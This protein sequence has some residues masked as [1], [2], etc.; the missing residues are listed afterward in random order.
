[1]DEHQSN[2]IS[3]LQFVTWGW[4]IIPLCW[5]NDQ[6]NCGCGRNHGGA[7]KA[8]LTTKGVND[9]SDQFH[10]VLRWWNRWPEANI[11]IDLAKSGLFV[12]GPDSVEWED[13]FRRQGLPETLTA[14][15]GG[16]EGHYHYYY[17]KPENV[18][19]TRLNRSGEYDLQTQGYMVAAPS[20]HQSGNH[21][22]WL[23]PEM[24]EKRIRGT[25]SLP[26]PPQ[27]AI[28][29]L[30]ERGTENKERRQEPTWDA[31]PTPPVID[32][33]NLDPASHKWW[34]GEAANMAGKN[35]DRSTTLFRLGTILAKRGYD[36]PTIIAALH[37][38]DV[39]LGYNKFARRADGGIRAYSDIATKVMIDERGRVNR[40]RNPAPPPD[41]YDDEGNP[42]DPQAP[43][44]PT[45][46]ADDIGRSRVAEYFQHVTR[47]RHW[48]SDNMRR[49]L[50]I[51]DTYKWLPSHVLFENPH[52]YPSKADHVS[53]LKYADGEWAKENHF[54]GSG[55]RINPKVTLAERCLKPGWKWCASHGK[56]WPSCGYC[57]LKSCPS[58]AS[59]TARD[60]AKV[61]LPY[62]REGD[63][64]YRQVWFSIP[65]ELPEDMMDWEDV[66]YRQARRMIALCG[67]KLQEKLKR[68]KNCL[69]RIYHRAT[70]FHLGYPVT[71]IHQKMVFFEAVDGELDD[72][73]KHL[74]EDL[75]GTVAYD[76]GTT[77]GETAV[78]QMIADS[79]ATLASLDPDGELGEEE[80]H[81][82]FSAYWSGTKGI[83]LI[84]PMD[85]VTK[86]VEEV[87]PEVA[88]VCP[89]EGCGLKLSW[90]SEEQVLAEIIPEPVVVG[91]PGPGDGGWE[92]PLF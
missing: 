51:G 89:V 34:T 2:L 87:E 55:L 67:H 88:D 44:R 78:L 43:S 73:I 62:R 8:P 5:P 28:T 54:M 32:A 4:S 24:A 39:A 19:Q 9:S 41:L 17:R 90:V 71:T 84:R 42:I 31:L 1:M 58:C 35:V 63:G 47:A 52:L 27:W 46:P 14:K 72:I 36:E 40:P 25:Y 80:R 57:G 37:E 53:W 66:I 7:G 11:G 21:Y 30:Q 20:L 69:S 10:T 74:A 61:T 64:R 82:L 91:P 75:G 77:N 68:R 45:G 6:G 76:I 85:I 26:E 70:S 22:S 49:K 12:V 65:V 13:K 29:L 83:R 60:M 18:A 92:I 33:T 48:E 3:A 79:V 81:N 23:D 86:A 56:Q 38:R 16:G 50:F 59:K 15:S